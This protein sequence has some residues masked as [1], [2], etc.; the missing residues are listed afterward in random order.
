ML[1]GAVL[2]LPAMAADVETT[3]VYLDNGRLEYV[4]LLDSTANQRLF[5]L[6]EKLATK[7]TVLAI[8]SRGGEVYTGMQLGAW[9]HAHKLD[10]RVVEFCMSS[11]AN[12]VFPAGVRKTVSNFAVIG[13]HGGPGDAHHLQFDEATQRRIDAMTAAEKKVFMDDLVKSS[14]ADGQREA[15]Y[16]QQIG[17]RADATSLGQQPRYKQILESNPDGAVWTYTLEDFAALGVR[18][19]TVINPPWKPGSAMHP[20]PVVMI[21]VEKN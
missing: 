18:N 21:P 4:G 9:V 10:V 16:L 13:Y 20:N 5:D 3:Q 17:V 14:S 19:I 8:R 6:Y 1:V 12:Y 2:A 15:E 7:P 11:C